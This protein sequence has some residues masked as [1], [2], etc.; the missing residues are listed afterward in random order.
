ML[1]QVRLAEFTGPA[2]AFQARCHPGQVDKGVP[3]SDGPVTKGGPVKRARGLGIGVATGSSVPRGLPRT[4]SIRGRSGSSSCCSC[5]RP[6]GQEPASWL[7][8]V[9]VE[10]GMAAP[11]GWASETGASPRSVGS[12]YGDSWP[13][14]DPRRGSVGSGGWSWPFL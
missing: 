4:Q 6:L 8:L 7:G 2:A 11:I 13:H 12:D 3:G 9:R 5:G 14:R 10:T 1:S